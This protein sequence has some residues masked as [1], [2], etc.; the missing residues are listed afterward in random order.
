MSMYSLNEPHDVM[1]TDSTMAL[2]RGVKVAV[3]KVDK[4]DLNLTRNDLIEL[5]NVS[6]NITFSVPDKDIMTMFFMIVR[7]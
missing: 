7:T 4:A 3:Y 5:V 6:H 1:S 2:Y